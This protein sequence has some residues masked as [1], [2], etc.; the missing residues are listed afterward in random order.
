MLP[1]LDLPGPECDRVL[2][3]D[4][5]PMIRKILQSWL[6]SWGYGVS[7]AQ[8][9]AQALR[10]LESEPPP[11]ILIFDWMMPE[12]N[13]LEL[14]RLVR[15]RNRTPYQFIMLAT[16]RDDKQDLVRGLEAG[17]DDYLSKPFDRNELRARLRTGRRILTLQSEQ[18]KAREE[19]QQ[20]ATHD[21][22]TGIWNRSAIFDL[23]HREFEI[24]LRSGSTL[25]IMML[26]VDSFKKV[27]D[28]HGHLAGD[29]VLREITRRILRALR[30]TDLVGRYGGEEFLILLPNCGSHEVRLC[31]ERILESMVDRPVTVDSSEIA[32]TVSLG[33]T[34]LDPALS[35]EKEALAAAD[36]ALY[37][38]KKSGRNRVASQEL[39]SA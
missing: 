6:S 18:L 24:A 10:L 19:F 23:V 38:A 22:L 33:T 31:A 30:S 35:A 39:R 5:D 29:E 13:G 2:I 9:G 7:A 11:Q 12:L 21:H 32:I 36:N 37:I 28:T 25:G 3:A 26:D 17:A 14:C 4:D 27:N 20:Q 8:D 34:V 15:A 16:A 1:N